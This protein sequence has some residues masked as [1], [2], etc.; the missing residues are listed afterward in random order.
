MAP[1][2]TASPDQPATGSDAEP[3]RFGVRDLRN[4]TALVI[5][6]AERS[7]AVYIT[8]NG[9]VVAKLIPHRLEPEGRTPTR[10]LLDRIANLQRS[11]TGWSDDHEEAK[12][13]ETGAQDD[14]PWG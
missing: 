7:G 2:D 10:R 3:R 9:E 14:D 1:T 13:F 11:N 4:D 12:R 5:A 6:E 8:R